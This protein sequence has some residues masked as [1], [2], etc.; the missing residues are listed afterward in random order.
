LHVEAV[1]MNMSHMMDQVAPTRPNGRP[2]GA[3]LLAKACDVLEAVAASPGGISQAELAAQLALPRTTTYRIL[4][5][6]AARGLLRQDPSRRGYALGFRF[7]ELARGVWSAPD[8][9]AAA[10][11]E[12]R[13]LRDLTGETAYVGA[14][15]GREVLS[16]A[17]DEGAHPVRSAARLGQRKPLHCTSQ[18]KA[19]LAFLPDGER[20]ALLRTLPLKPLTS[21][22]ITDRRHLAAALRIIRTRGFAT[23]DE[24][25]LD[26]IRC[27]GAPILDAQDRVLGAV[28]VAGPAWRMTLERLDLLGPEL[29][30]AG[31][32][33]GA[34]LRPPVV[35]AAAG[36]AEAVPGSPAA[37]LGL[38][39][40]WSNG[41]LW[42]ADALAPQLRRLG[43]GGDL[44]VARLDLPLAALAPARDGSLLLADAE[45]LLHLA[46]DGRK[47]ARQALASPPLALRAAPDGEAWASLPLEGGSA[48]GR[49]AP[50]GTLR[51]AWRLPGLVR[52]LA[53]APDG[54]A[55][56]AAAPESGTVHRLQ[57]G[58]PAAMLVTRLPAGGGRP[59]GLAVD[60]G[61]GLWVAL[62]DGW[63]VAR[64]GEDG[65]IERV[66]PLPVPRPIDLGF[67]GADGATLYVTTARHGVGPAVL[68]SAPLS[69]RLLAVGAGAAGVAEPL[70]RW[71]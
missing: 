17:R 9:P 53:W 66:V 31:R 49:L 48:I 11:P 14:L 5:T 18:G 13:L 10:A 61:G 23:D 59:A 35:E 15:E 34:Q 26:G 64:L 69:G 56:F 46:A 8:L 68:A 67:G 63:S 21:R 71:D 42:W 50:D 2:D 20:E 39:P 58:R 27:V 47:L 16:L 6:L 36:A 37:F 70:L 28:S 4:A 22:T 33:I 54:A 65:E 19:I 45:G 32:R 51:A 29:A 52:S 7:L 44:A 3:A 30:A 55:L 40:R 60:R 24:E 41:G 57:P 43:A 12:L 25:I 38:A 62:C 1:T